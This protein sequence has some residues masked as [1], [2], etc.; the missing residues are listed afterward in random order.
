MEKT[1]TERINLGRLDESAELPKG[2]ILS[3]RLSF[4]EPLQFSENPDAPLDKVTAQV[5]DEMRREG[6]PITQPEVAARIG[7]I[8][9]LLRAAGDQSATST[10]DDSEPK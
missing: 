7:R 5:L 2:K 10:K 4:R 1:T 6:V 9:R 3:V 8:G